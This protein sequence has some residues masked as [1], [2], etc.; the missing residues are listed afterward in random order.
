MVRKTK[1]STIIPA[2][3]SGYYPI[4][5]PSVSELITELASKTVNAVTS[6]PRD[7]YQL[8]KAAALAAKDTASYL[9][10]KVDATELASELAGAFVGHKAGALLGAGTKKLVEKLGGTVPASNYAKNEVYKLSKKHFKKVGK[11]V[12]SD[13]KKAVKEKYAADVREAFGEAGSSESMRSL[14]KLEL[15]TIFD[16]AA[17][18]GGEAEASAAMDDL[19][20]LIFAQEYE[21]FDDRKAG[22]DAAL[23]DHETVMKEPGGESK[24]YMD[25]DDHILFSTDD[26]EEVKYTTGIPASILPSKASLHIGF[27]NPALEEYTNMLIIQNNVSHLCK[28]LYLYNHSSNR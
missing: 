8:V 22:G 2:H 18:A 7:G 15:Q 13:A 5:R 23:P 12:A 24:I 28:L 9:L 6:I 11:T 4:P 21:S 25:D 26:D 16:S 17:G 14:K 19:Q 27:D 1:Q 3:E 20:K 10:D